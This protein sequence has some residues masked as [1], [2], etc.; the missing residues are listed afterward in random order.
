MQCY[1]IGQSYFQYMW[2]E[3]LGGCQIAQNVIYV[4]ISAVS[5]FTCE[6]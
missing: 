1:I 5:K 3:M 4:W 6:G 2:T